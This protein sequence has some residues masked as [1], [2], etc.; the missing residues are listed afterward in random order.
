[1]PLRYMLRWALAAVG[2]GVILL[3]ALFATFALAGSCH[4]RPLDPQA[5]SCGVASPLFRGILIFA[6]LVAG[7][8]GATA[9]AVRV[10]PSHNRVVATVAVLAPLVALAAAQWG[11]TAV[12]FSYYSDVAVPLLL[13]IPGALCAAILVRRKEHP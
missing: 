5:F 6:P 8:V 13:V 10:A 3:G 7:H 1:M 4:H 9:L 2:Y 11:Q 12:E